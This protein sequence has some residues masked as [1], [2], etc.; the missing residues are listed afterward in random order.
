M[1]TF[2][3]L[4]KNIRFIRSLSLLFFSFLLISCGDPEK[5][6]S[7]AEEENTIVKITGK[8][9]LVMGVNSPGG[10][11]SIE[12]KDES[13]QIHLTEET[14]LIGFEQNE[15][16]YQWEFGHI[17]EVMGKIVPS[18]SMYNTFFEENTII[19]KSIKYIGPPPYDPNEELISAIYIGSLDK[20]KE[21]IKNGADIQK[22]INYGSYLHLAASFCKNP[23]VI[24]YLIK[25]GA[26]VNS[27]NGRNGN[28]PL[29][30]AR[31]L[32]IAKILVKNGANPRLKIEDGKLPIDVCRSS[33]I[34]EYLLR[35]K[36]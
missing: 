31:N 27:T 1:D 25:N 5:D 12:D 8:T 24:D 23:V 21:A 7:K 30:V 11:I 9:S 2:F 18:N 28:T 14:K 10:G 36:Q 17:Y 6:F 16:Q 33:Q 13:Y 19:A 34:R 20:V 29:H 26:D 32:E 35:Y 22:K 15:G 4:T 3:L